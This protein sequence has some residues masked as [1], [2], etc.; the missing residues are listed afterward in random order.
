[1]INTGQSGFCD[2]PRSGE[3]LVGLAETASEALEQV[4]RE[5]VGREGR[6][7]AGKKGGASGGGR[8]VYAAGEC[9]PVLRSED[10]QRCLESAL[11][12]V[13]G[14]LPQAGGRAVESGCFMRLSGE[15]FFDASLAVDLDLIRDI[16]GGE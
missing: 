15:E 11:G 7:A 1:M 8:M 10:C 14:C 16:G 2:D 12:N 3:G 4:A 13:K 5:V 9:L 6:F